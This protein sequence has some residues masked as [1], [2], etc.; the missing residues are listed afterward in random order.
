MRSI[1]DNVVGEDDE[2]D[3]TSETWA[4][5]LAGGPGDDDSPRDEARV[6]RLDDKTKGG[7]TDS[8]CTGPLVVGTPHF[9]P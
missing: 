1:E 9:R 3:V 7:G 8:Q 6:V 5:K 4:C 2:I